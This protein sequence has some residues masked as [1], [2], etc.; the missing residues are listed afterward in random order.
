MWVNSHL[1]VDPRMPFGG[2]KE[3]G[4]GMERGMEGL[5]HDTN[6]KSLSVWKR[7]FE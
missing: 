7:V 3:S 2:H 4:V 6:S 1:D 5:K